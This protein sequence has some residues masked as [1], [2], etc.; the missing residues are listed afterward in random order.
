MVTATAQTLAITW[1][2]RSDR[3]VRLLRCM[4]PTL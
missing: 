3:L 1:M 2:D 4:T